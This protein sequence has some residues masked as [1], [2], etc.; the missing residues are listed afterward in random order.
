M[1][2][3]EIFNP[4]G[5]CDPFSCKATDTWCPRPGMYGSAKK[6]CDAKDCKEITP[7]GTGNRCHIAFCQV[8]KINEKLHLGNNGDIADEDYPPDQE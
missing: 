7:N 6:G 5:P 3:C 4:K 1:A 8:R 2:N